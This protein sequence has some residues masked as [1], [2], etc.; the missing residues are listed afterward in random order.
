M[1]RVFRFGVGWALVLA[2]AVPVAASAGRDAPTKRLV[3][4]DDDVVGLSGAPALLLKLGQFAAPNLGAAMMNG[5]MDVWSDRAEPGED[6]TGALYEAPPGASGVDGGRRHPER[7]RKAA[8]VAGG[9]AAAGVAA[10]TAFF[11]RRRHD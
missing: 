3:L 9:V 11:W 7:R 6:D 4:I 10:A 8:I 2:L 5:F 1:R